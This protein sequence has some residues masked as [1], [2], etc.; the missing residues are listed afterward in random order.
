V[1]VAAVVLIALPLF[2]PTADFYAGLVGGVVG[3]L[4][5]VAASAFHHAE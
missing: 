4:A 3:G 5:G 1:A 2:A